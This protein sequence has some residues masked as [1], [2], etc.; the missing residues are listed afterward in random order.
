LAEFP[1]ARTALRIAKG[2]ILEGWNIMGRKNCKENKKQQ[3]KG[4]NE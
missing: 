2:A 1:Y 4:D 3:I